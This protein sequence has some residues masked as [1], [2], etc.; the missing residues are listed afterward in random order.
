MSKLYYLVLLDCFPLLMHFLTFLVKLIFWLKFFHRQR[1]AE[2]GVGAGERRKSILR[3]FNT[4]SLP[5]SSGIVYSCVTC[6]LLQVILFLNLLT[7]SSVNPFSSRKLSGYLLVSHVCSTSQFTTLWVE[8]NALLYFT[9]SN[10]VGA[11]TKS[12]NFYIFW[13][14]SSR[15][16]FQFRRLL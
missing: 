12:V 9:L 6:V 7:A 4:S 14:Q 1:Q 11:L 10:P 15:S 8:L 2:D 3:Y 16:S 5:W 13:N